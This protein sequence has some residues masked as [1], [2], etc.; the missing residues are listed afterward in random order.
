MKIIAITGGGAG[1]GRGIAWHF[2]RAGWGVSITDADKVAGQE[3][4]QVMKEAGTK[5]IFVPGDVSRPADVNRWLKTTKDRLG[6]PD[7]ATLSVGEASD[8]GSA[9]A[10]LGAA[11]LAAVWVRPALPTPL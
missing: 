3:C 11:A 1:I 5:A 4:L 9:V 10:Q 2:A 7:V 6:V 8:E